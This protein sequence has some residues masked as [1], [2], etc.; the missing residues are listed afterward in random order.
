MQ[1]RQPRLS[2]KSEGIQANSGI[3]TAGLASTLTGGD[4]NAN[5]FDIDALT[6]GGEDGSKTEEEV[7]SDIAK[8]LHKA[9]RW[10]YYKE[11]I[12]M[13]NRGAEVDSRDPKGN[14]PLH[15]ACQ[16]GHEALAK[17]LVER[18]A[19]INAQNHRGNTALHFAFTY[20]Y[21]I[22]GEHL[23]SKGADERILNDSDCLCYEGLDPQDE[24]KEKEKEK[25]VS[26]REK[27]ATKGDSFIRKKNLNSS[28]VLSVMKLGSDATI[29][30][31]GSRLGAGT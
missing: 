12:R 19:N 16:N 29:S 18:G 6:R 8:V 4:N 13:L 23:V 25:A 7:N 20:G 14:T 27:P 30:G 22:I 31:F 24:E 15:T 1:P 2:T 21:N 5:Q 28:Q 9:T 11:V 17:L 3:L 26:G 10:G